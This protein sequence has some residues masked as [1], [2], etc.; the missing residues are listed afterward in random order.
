[1]VNLR[2]KSCVII[3]TEIEIFLKF[4]IMEKE[5]YGYEEDRFQFE[6]TNI[7]YDKEYND[8]DFIAEDILIQKQMVKMQ[9]PVTASASH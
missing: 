8:Y 7:V 3:H 6:E 1:M 5:N 9:L 2:E 4:V